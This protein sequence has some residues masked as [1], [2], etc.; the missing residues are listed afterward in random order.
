MTRSIHHCHLSSPSCAKRIR[1]WHFPSEEFPKGWGRTSN[2]SQHRNPHRHQQRDR[3]SPNY[4]FSSPLFTDLD[5]YGSGLNYQPN[6]RTFSTNINTLPVNCQCRPRGKK[7]LCT[8]WLCWVPWGLSF[9]TWTCRFLCVLTRKKGKFLLIFEEI[10]L[11]S[12]WWGKETEMLQ[13]NLQSKQP[14]VISVYQMLT[15]TQKNTDQDKS[16]SISRNLAT[17]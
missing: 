9:L 10:R 16:A 13:T 15:H 6:V 7:Y 2:P 3:G 5:V 4:A 12:L 11:C 8:L 17:A 1:R 14:F